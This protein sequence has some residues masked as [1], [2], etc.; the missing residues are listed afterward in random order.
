MW[1]KEAGAGSRAATIRDERKE[2]EEYFQQKG[3]EAQKQKSREA[4]K[5]D[6]QKRKE[7]G[8][9]KNQR[10][11]KSKKRKNQEKQRSREAGKHRTRNA[12]KTNLPGKRKQPSMLSSQVPNLCPQTFGWMEI[13]KDTRETTNLIFSIFQKALL[14]RHSQNRVCI[15][16]QPQWQQG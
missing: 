5:A 8:K 4:G 6:E 13:A 15:A 2:N 7:A 14:R 12:P 10:G 1:S 16:G 9:A 3:T 11:M